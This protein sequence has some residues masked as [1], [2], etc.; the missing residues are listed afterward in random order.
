M[1]IKPRDWIIDTVCLFVMM[2]SSILQDKDT[3]ELKWWETT[4]CGNYS[5]LKQLGKSAI[6]GRNLRERIFCR[7][8]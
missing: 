4:G 3:R 8:E 7:D 1:P 2:T 6:S 5:K